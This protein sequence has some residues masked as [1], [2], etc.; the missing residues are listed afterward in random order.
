MTTAV[1][2]EG[3]QSEPVSERSFSSI[4]RRASSRPRSRANNPVGSEGFYLEEDI[5]K[6]DPELKS[7]PQTTELEKS[8]QNLGLGAA[9]DTGAGV[10]D[11]EK[12]HGQ[13]ADGGLG[14]IERIFKEDPTMFPFGTFVSELFSV[15]TISEL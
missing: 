4:S 13:D 5:V 1:N 3:F 14:H 15:P 11:R 6:P 12:S 10:S 7:S 2:G 9:K 8:I